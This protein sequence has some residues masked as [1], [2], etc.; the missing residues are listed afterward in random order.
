MQNSVKYYLVAY[1]VLA[2]CAWLAYLVSFAWSG[3]ALEGNSLVLLNIAQGLAILEIAHIVFKLVKSPLAS[4]IAQVFSR[5]LVLLLIDY[6]VYQ[7]LQ[8]QALQAGILVVSA[9][10]G[11]TELVRYSFYATQLLNNQPRLLLW[12]RYTFFIVL[13][14]IGVFGEWLIIATPIF[15]SGMVFNLYNLAM[16]FVLLSY[17]YYFPV[18]Y[19]YM[20]KQRKAKL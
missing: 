16:A 13:Y 17:V 9:A 3:F 19:K 6:F 18:L 4:T 10:W 2:F 5:L 7:Q 20:W 12:M 8:H 1:N 11:I 14:P 15:I